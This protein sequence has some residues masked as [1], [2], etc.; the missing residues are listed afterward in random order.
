MAK[1]S[2]KSGVAIAQEHV[3]ALIDY[4]ERM[5]GTALPRYMTELNRSV[6]AKECGFDRKVFQTNPRCADLLEAADQ[7]DRER[8]LSRLEQAETVRQEKAKVNSDR[9]NLEAQNLRL[10]AENM[11]LRRELERSRRLNT[12]MAER[13]KVPP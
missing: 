7:A 13:G 2:G 11:S 10:M 3:D 12:L 5:K 9:A 8:Y 1:S 6:I 4:L